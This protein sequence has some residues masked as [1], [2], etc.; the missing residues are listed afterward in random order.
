VQFLTKVY[1]EV[2]GAYW[3]FSWDGWAVIFGKEEPPIE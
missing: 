3:S 1:K 2:G